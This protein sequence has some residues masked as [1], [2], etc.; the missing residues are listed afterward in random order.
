MIYVDRTPHGS[1]LINDLIF[2]GD[3][4]DTERAFPTWSH[5]VRTLRKGR[6]GIY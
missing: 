3:H 1:I 2:V 6:H 5:F 4:P